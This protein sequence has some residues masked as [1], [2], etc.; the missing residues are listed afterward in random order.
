MQT[1]QT[2]IDL[3]LRSSPT[4]TALP[5]LCPLPPTGVI[6]VAGGDALAF[7]QG[8]TTCDVRRI[9]ENESGLGAFCNPEG[10]VIANF[11]ILRHHQDFLLLLS[12]DLLQPL[13][14]RLN[15]YVLRADVRLSSEETALFGVIAG[16]EGTLEGMEGLPDSPHRA[17]SLEGL[18]W[19]RMPPPGVRWLVL[20]PKDKAQA[21]WLRMAQSHPMSRQPAS[22][23]LLAEIHSGLPL[24][25]QATSELFLPQM[26]NLDVLGAI[27]FDKGCYTGQEII[28][29]THYRGQVKRRLYRGRVATSRTISPGEKLICQEETVGQVANAAPT[30]EGQELLAVVRC[31][32]AAQTEIHLAD[33]LEGSFQWLDLAYTLP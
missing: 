18:T 19:I 2:F 15:L 8:Q 30:A 7:L 16:E 23:W 24:V 13:L 9:S 20:G 27:S 21:M 10:R 12:T 25:T 17:V 14:K 31:D 11:R 22:R 29:R 32:R 4:E 33:N 26:L 1:W 5:A 28:A 3:Q 6:R